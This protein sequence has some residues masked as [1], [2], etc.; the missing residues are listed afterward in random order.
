MKIL[1]F[2]GERNLFP[3][4]IVFTL[5]LC[6]CSQPQPQ[7]VTLDVT[8]LIRSGNHA[9]ATAKLQEALVSH[10]RDPILLYNLALIQRQQNRLADA[11]LTISKAQNNAPEDDAINM[12]YTDIL[13]ESGKEQEAW[14]QFMKI[15]EQGRQ[16]RQGQFLQGIILS[17]MGDYQQA[18]SAL[19]AAMALGDQSAIT[20]AALAF[21]VLKLGRVDEAQDLLKTAEAAQ[22]ASTDAQRQIAETYLSI[23]DAQ[24]A[25]EIAKKLIEANANDARLY[26][27]LGKAEMILLQFG[28]SESAFTRALACPNA[29]PWTQVAYAEMLFA[30]KRE[31]ESLMQ[32]L[33]AEEKITFSREPM[34]DPKL[35]NLLATLYA[36]KSQ[37]LLAHKY[38]NLSLQVE[39]MQPRVKELVQ[40]MVKD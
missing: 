1:R 29:T 36:R 37:P 6:S 34:R 32:A 30:V 25:K 9:E 2:F 15:G 20:Q 35:Y 16:S 13:L 14:D 17:R 18:E 39:P 38:L 19:R 23:G 10:P 3:I 11:L 5:G 21:V 40:K 26:T 7:T 27:L 24:K 4:A 12:L 8:E 31:D 33:K 28:E 22:G